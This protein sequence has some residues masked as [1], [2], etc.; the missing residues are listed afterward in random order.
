MRCRQLQAKR[1]R[2]ERLAAVK[3]NRVDERCVPKK[4][5]RGKTGVVAGCA[6]CAEFVVMNTPSIGSPPQPTES[7]PPSSNVS[8][9]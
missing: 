8:P 5:L 3:A 7:G 2:D 4:M 6:F 9:G 1:W